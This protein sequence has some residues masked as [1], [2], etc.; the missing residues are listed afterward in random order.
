MCFSGAAAALGGV[1]AADSAEPEGRGARAGELRAR[2]LLCERPEAVN[3][4][5][6]ARPAAKARRAA[7]PLAARR[8]RG[9][10]RTERGEGA[11]CVRVGSG[12]RKGKE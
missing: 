9:L 11:A 10:H 7:V 6:R 3:S 1:A 2:W 8:A 5:R 12:A 4:R